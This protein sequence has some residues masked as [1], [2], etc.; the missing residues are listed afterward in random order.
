MI[1]ILLIMASC[2]PMSGRFLQK[3]PRGGAPNLQSSTR[4]APQESLSAFR[5]FEQNRQGLL[6]RTTALGAETKIFN[7]E[8]LSGPNNDPFGHSLKWAGLNEK[9]SAH[10]NSWEYWLKSE[11]LPQHHAEVHPVALDQ[12]KSLKDIQSLHSSHPD[13]PIISRTINNHV[14]LHYSQK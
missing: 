9:I 2:L 8:R 1:I 3:K 12:L 11:L 7:N 10:R 13:M 4:T 14:A 6:D 5:N